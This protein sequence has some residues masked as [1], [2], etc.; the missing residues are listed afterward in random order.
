MRKIFTITGL[1]IA[2]ILSVAF[3]NTDESTDNLRRI[4][5]RPP[6]QWPKPFV[7]EGVGWK[8]L[9][10][11]PQSPLQSQMDSLKH[12]IDLGKKLFFDPRLSGSGKLSCATCHKPE[13]N[14]TDGIEKSIG[15][16]GALNQRNSPTIQNT[17]FYKKLFWDGRSNSLEDQAFAPINSESEMHGDMREL[18]FK[19]R[20]IKGYVDLFDAAY[21]DPGINP[22]R[23]ALAI[24]TFEKTIISRNSRF[25][26][27]LNGS[28]NALNNSEI[29][30]LHLFRTKAR[31]MNCHNGPMFSDNSFHRNNITFMYDDD[32]YYKVTH[33]EEDKRKFKTPSLRDV[34]RTGP[35]MHNGKS[36]SLEQVISRYSVANFPPGEASPLIKNLGLSQKEQK[37]VL[38]FL[39]AISADPVPFKK[40]VLPE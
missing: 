19:L 8:E 33:Q 1:F 31:C 29:R 32:G 22:D 37:D 30:G 26:K 9:G 36:N 27:F 28:T 4:Y 15:H 23:I 38:A 39:K 34:A 12:L 17:W 7:D 24:A 20:K 11:L 16:E 40:P 14:W 25:D 35:W 5:S 6:D 2:V 13:L 21:G 3:S 18:P 10:V